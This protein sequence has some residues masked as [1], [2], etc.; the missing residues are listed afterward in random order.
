M[1]SLLFGIADYN[2]LISVPWWF[3]VLAV[4]VDLGV[5]SNR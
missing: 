2:D 5:L 3:Y 4:A 1:I